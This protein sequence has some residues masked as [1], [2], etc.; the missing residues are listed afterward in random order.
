M[1]GDIVNEPIMVAARQL[2][3]EAGKWSSK[4]SDA[5]IHPDLS[6][7]ELTAAREALKLKHL[8]RSDHLII[9]SYILNR[10]LFLKSFVCF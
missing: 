3:D 8:Q 1:A 7:H 2:H 10:S 4:V 5:N 9:D 6:D